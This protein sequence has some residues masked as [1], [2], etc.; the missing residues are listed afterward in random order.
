MRE[1]LKRRCDPRFFLYRLKWNHAHR[2]DWVLPFPTNIDIEPTGRC[3]LKCVM[4]PQAFEEVSPEDARMIDLGLVRKVVDEAAGNGV[5]S[6]KFTWRGEPAL[7]NGLVEMVRYC[8]SKGVPEVQFTTN[9]TP[10]TERKIRDLIEAGLDRIIF[11]LDG[12]RK[13]TVEKI[14][15]GLNYDRAV[16]TIKTFHRLRGE[17]G[18]IK[19]FIRIQMVRMEQNKDEVGDFIRTW[20]PYAD[21]IRVADVTDRGQGGH[22]AVGDQVAVGRRRCPQPWQRMVVAP[23]GE[24]LP[25]CADWRKEWVIGDVRSQSLKEIWHG[26][27]MEAMRQVQREMQ[28]D[29]VSPC[30]TCFVAESYAWEKVAAAGTPRGQA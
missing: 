16:E 27:K 2:L 11:S 21:D 9:G 17:T 6:I 14:R 19:P 18:R 8:K 5:Y 23:T 25:C 12:A 30:R 1:F 13:D 29:Q 26:P 28:L 7:H 20:K 4:C 10:Y 24:V 3:N 22:L 15:V